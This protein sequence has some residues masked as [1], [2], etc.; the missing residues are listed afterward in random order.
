MTARFASVEDAVQA[1]SDPG[2]P[3]WGDAFAYL[4]CQPETASL[5]IETFR[6][7]L[8]ELGIPPTG[9]DAG[10]GEPAYALA[11]IA[12]AMGVPERDMEQTVA[13]AAGAPDER[14]RP[15]LR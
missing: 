14:M 2:S 13:A 11:D 1:L 8:E 9:I 3:A 6:E 10:T 12:R 4:S 5:M 15:C 7:T